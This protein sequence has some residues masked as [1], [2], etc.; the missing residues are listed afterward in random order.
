MFFV[1]PV[2]RTGQENTPKYP[3]PSSYERSFKMMRIL[4]YIIAIVIGAAAVIVGISGT[5]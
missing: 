5:T 4:G 3:W 2:P 1:I